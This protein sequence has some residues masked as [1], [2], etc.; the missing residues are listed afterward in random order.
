M[1][2]YDVVL[3][4]TDHPTSRYLI[5]DTCVLLGKPLVSASALRIDG[6]L[7][8]LNNPPLKP[9]DSRGGPCYRCVFPKPPPPESLLSCGDGGILGP[10]VGVMGVLQALEAIKIIIFEE[11]VAPGCNGGLTAKCQEETDRIKLESTEFKQGNDHR[12]LIFSAFPDITFRS[13]R[14]RAR[15]LDC[16]ACSSKGTITFEGLKDG[17]L[18]YTR[19]CGVPE[20]LQ[21]IAPTERI[22]V[23]QLAAIRIG[24]GNK[25]EPY[26]RANV[27]EV[28]MESEAA[29]NEKSRL[30]ESPTTLKDQLK[31][32]YALVDVRNSAQFEIA[33]LPE[34][35]NI[36]FPAI[37]STDYST[38]QIAL[39]DGSSF[40]SLPAWATSLINL[41]EKLP[42]HV[43]CRRGNDSQIVV[44]RLK[45]LGLHKNGERYIG[46][47]VG[48]IEEWTKFYG[49]TA[50]GFPQY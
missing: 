43:V 21:G 34:S 6:Q 13:V 28:D 39:P 32:P 29:A 4:C 45:Q 22:S 31:Q 10:V 41:P 48:G 25:H 23:Q 27:G 46:D 12:L 20:Q 2:Q 30:K 9:G 49:A 40:A 5:S 38:T 1:V 36:P 37:E 24:G 8:V 50:D 26:H 3:D 11:V 14:I 17:S 35:I 33:H 16:A 7:L 42:I 18:D 19:F 47:I 15:R 44:R